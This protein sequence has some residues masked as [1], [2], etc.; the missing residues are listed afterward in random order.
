[1]AGALGAA[2]REHPALEIAVAHVLADGRAGD[3][4][5]ERAA[6]RGLAEQAAG[7]RR[8]V[9]GPVAGEVPG[10][11]RGAHLARARVA[12]VVG[13]AVLVGLVEAA[14]VAAGDATLRRPGEIR[15][16]G[17]RQTLLAAD[18]PSDE[19]HAKPDAKPDEERRRG[20]PPAQPPGTHARHAI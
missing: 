3:A 11:G 4:E 14:S 5:A 15:R 17:R 10:P 7:A 8:A 20:D 18:E 1:M 12:P 6:D 2:A 16:V 19:P 9:L 13:V